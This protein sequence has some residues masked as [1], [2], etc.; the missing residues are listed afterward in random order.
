MEHASDVVG[1]VDNLEHA[2]ATAALAETVTSRANTR[3][4]SLEIRG[5]LRSWGMLAGE[6]AS[7]RAASGRPHEVVASG[8]D[9]SPEAWGTSERPWGRHHLIPTG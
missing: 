2:H 4:R 9:E 6:R 8:A 1:V 7:S 5:G 3:A